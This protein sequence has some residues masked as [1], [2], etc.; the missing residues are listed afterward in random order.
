NKTPRPVAIRMA[1]ADDVDGIARVFLDSAVYHASL[2]PARYAVPAVDTISAHY[3]ARSQHLQHPYANDVTLIAELDGEIVGFIDARMD[4]SPDLM[5]RSMSYCHIAEIAV[6]PH[7]QHEGIGAR[8]L[9]A[10]EDWGRRLGAQLAS[11]EYHAANTPASAFYRRMGYSV[12]A[13]IAI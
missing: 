6:S 13:L 11:L 2:D 8:L 12:A 4:E 9:N 7:H 5:H 3:R 1:V 10:A